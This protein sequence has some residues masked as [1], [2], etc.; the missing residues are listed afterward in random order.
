[1]YDF[2]LSIDLRPATQ[3]HTHAPL[4]TN[5]SEPIPPL[6]S[7]YPIIDKKEETCYHGCCLKKKA[8]SMRTN[9]NKNHHI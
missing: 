3:T 2:H 6:T 1:M 5:T 4:F 7:P 8:A 9:Y